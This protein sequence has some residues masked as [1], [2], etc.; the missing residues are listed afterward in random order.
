MIGHVS[1]GGGF[2]AHSTRFLFVI[3]CCVQLVLHALPASAN[4]GEPIATS[5]NWTVRQTLHAIT[6]E[7]S[8]VAIYKDRFEIQLD[9]NDLFI[10]LRESGGVSSLVLRFDDK[11]AR[12][13]R[14]AS[15]AEKRIRS[16]NLRGPEFEELMSSKR[17]RA[18]I[19]TAAGAIIEEDLD[20][21]GA[22]EALGELMRSPCCEPPR[23]GFLAQLGGWC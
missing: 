12:E 18:Q 4:F 23:C 17:L 3:A 2:M 9:P 14:P 7:P 1:W 10:S 20:L 5:G 19:R 15:E 16:V 8:C 6:D 21:N 11:P 22:K 13:A